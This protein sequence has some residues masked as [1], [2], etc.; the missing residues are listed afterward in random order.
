MKYRLRQWRHSRLPAPRPVPPPLVTFLS[1]HSCRDRRK[2]L[3]SL[4]CNE[5]KVTGGEATGRGT[6]RRLCR[7]CRRR[8]FIQRISTNLLFVT[9]FLWPLFSGATRPQ[10]LLFRAASLAP[11][12]CR[13]YSDEQ[14][15][16]KKHLKNVGPIRHCE[17]PQAACF[18]LPFTRCLL[19]HAACASMSTTTSTTTTTTTT[20]DRRDRYG[21]TEWAQ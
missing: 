20:R 4:E 19:S 7:H 21:R 11:L 10:T 13:L 17:P 12:P 3:R 15:K 14:N 9:Q 6:G 18:T 5:R 2:S 1:L 8:Y 16:N